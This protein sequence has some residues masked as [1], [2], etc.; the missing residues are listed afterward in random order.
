[1]G[2][3]ARRYFFTR[4]TYIVGFNAYE[5]THT[6]RVITD[7][8]TRWVLQLW[9]SFKQCKFAP[10]PNSHIEHFDFLRYLIAKELT[11]D[12]EEPLTEFTT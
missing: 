6:F 5:H 7:Y 1:M 12:V 9:K 10:F 4:L 2:E 11:D 8:L 3:R